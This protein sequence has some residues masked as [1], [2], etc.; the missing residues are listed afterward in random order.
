M[1][2]TEEK[3]TFVYDPEG[4][5]NAVMV[6]GGEKYRVRAEVLIKKGDK[7]Y[8]NYTRRRNQY[9]RYYKIPGGSIMPSKSAEET[10]VCEARE[11]ARLLIKNVRFTCN[12]LIQRYTEI[13]EWH[14]RILWPLGLRYVG[15]VT[16]ICMAEAYGRYDGYVKPEDSEPDMLNNGKFYAPEVIP[17]DSAHADILRKEGLLQYDKIVY[18]WSFTKSVICGISFIYY[19]S[20]YNRSI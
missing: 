15:S 5:A 1:I 8:V 14:K 16:L 3:I 4:I 2:K 18:K 6:I 12:K 11:E 7:L 17:W 20:E 13:P 9:N 19:N 10:V